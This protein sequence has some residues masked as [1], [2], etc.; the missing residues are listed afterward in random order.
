MGTLPTP[1]PYQTRF[2]KWR[3]NEPSRHYHS[4]LFPNLLASCG[5]NRWFKVIWRVRGSPGNGVRRTRF[6]TLAH[7][8]TLG[9]S[10]L[11]QPWQLMSLQLVDSNICWCCLH[12]TLY[13]Y[14][15]R[16]FHLS[17]LDY[18]QGNPLLWFKLWLG[19]DLSFWRLWKFM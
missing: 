18:T 4:I 16:F 14:L 6:W 13:N 19:K 9:H 5:R 12:Y 11:N 7:Y 15:W 2:G 1:K 3:V 8:M 10:F 17:S